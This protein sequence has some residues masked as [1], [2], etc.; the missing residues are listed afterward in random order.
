MTTYTQAHCRDCKLEGKAI[1]EC[2]VRKYQYK[3][4]LKKCPKEIVALEKKPTPIPESEDETSFLKTTSERVGRITPVLMDRSG[5]II[6]GVHRLQ[7]DP[8]WFSQV[9]YD[10]DKKKDPVK[11]HLA[12][13]IV[14]V[15]R[16]QVSAE[17]KSEIL[18]E[19]AKLTKWTP[20]QI[21]EATGMSYRWILKY[22]PSE[23]KREY[24]VPESARRADL[25]QTTQ[26]VPSPQESEL[27]TQEVR[28]T[29]HITTSIPITSETAKLP[30]HEP[31]TPTKEAEAPAPEPL[32]VAEFTCP[33][34]KQDFRIVHVNRNLHRFMPVKK[35]ATS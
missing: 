11:F 4:L 23:Y 21:S 33:E 19:I 5:N 35:E 30:T 14:N 18:S 8:A 10:I 12:R 32:D 20:Q 34:C 31:I 17:E 26:N 1:D 28:R 13:L 15:C 9:V 22:L 6:D 7:A 2:L 24:E 3:A 29:E 16:R 25:T 27:S